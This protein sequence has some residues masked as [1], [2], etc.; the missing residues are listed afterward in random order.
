[1][2]GDDDDNDTLFALRRRMSV[3]ISWKV[4]VFFYNNEKGAKDLS[5]Y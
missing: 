5:V 3:S 1:M 2:I 4:W